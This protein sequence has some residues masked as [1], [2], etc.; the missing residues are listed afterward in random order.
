MGTRERWVDDKEAAA[1]GLLVATV[2]DS[3][4]TNP[5]AIMSGKAHIRKAGN[6]AV[7]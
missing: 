3:M 7:F 1:N 6:G 2:L 4:Q 5:G